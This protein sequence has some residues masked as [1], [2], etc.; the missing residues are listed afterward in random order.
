[1][2]FNPANNPGR[3][4]IATP[5]TRDVTSESAGSFYGDSAETATKSFSNTCNLVNI[6]LYN[7][8]RGT[9]EILDGYEINAAVLRTATNFAYFL[10][11][12]ADALAIM[13]VKNELGGKSA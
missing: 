4:K 3:N 11:N 1:M 10:K 9:G 7:E 8:V 2:A 13:S 5:S 6:A 12:G